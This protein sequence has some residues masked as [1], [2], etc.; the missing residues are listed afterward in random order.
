M[1]ITE[2]PIAE[3]PGVGRVYSDLD[4]GARGVARLLIDYGHR[5]IRFIG[6]FDDDNVRVSFTRELMNA[7][8]PLQDDLEIMAGAGGAGAWRCAGC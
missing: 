1:V 5:R 2:R 4:S 8:F 7:G 3:I 6:N